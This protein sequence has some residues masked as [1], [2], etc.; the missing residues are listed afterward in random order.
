MS[1]KLL[2][3]RIEQALNA[4]GAEQIQKVMQK[5]GKKPCGCAG[6]KHALNEWHRKFLQ[7]AEKIMQSQK[8]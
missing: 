3:D 4:L 5:V 6:R 1:R 2:G 8:K 7:E